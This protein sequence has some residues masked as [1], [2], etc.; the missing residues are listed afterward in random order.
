MPDKLRK[1]NDQSNYQLTMQ[2]GYILRRANQRHLTIFAEHIPVLTPTQFAALAKLCELGAVSQNE[3]GRQTSMDGA[4][5]KGV[6]DRLRK[7]NLVSTRPN[8]DDQRR[9]FVEASAQ[10]RELYNDNIVAAHNISEKTLQNLSGA[11]RKT[12]I[13]LL[14]KLT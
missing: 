6:V 1:Q 10:G 3:L 8:A 7:R 14:S 9:L 5:I 12:L 11:E 13:A 4:T 2:V